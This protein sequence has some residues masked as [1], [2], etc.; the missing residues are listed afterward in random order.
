MN[1]QGGYNKKNSYFDSFI[2]LTI[3]CMN[4]KFCELANQEMT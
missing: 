1:I 3:K 4:I 2:Y